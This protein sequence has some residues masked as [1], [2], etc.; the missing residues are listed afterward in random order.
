MSPNEGPFSPP[1]VVFYINVEDLDETNEAITENGGEILVEAM[2]VP[3]MGIFTIFQDPGGVINAA[4]ED[5]YEGEP[6]EGGWPMFTDQASDGSIVHF[7]LYTDDPEG[8]QAFHEA[9]FGWT[10]EAAEG[11][12]VMA[13]PPT[14]PYGGVMNAT[15]EMPVESLAYVLVEDAAEACEVIEGAQGEVLREPF[16][17]EG[18][19]TM[20][21]FEA[22]GEIVLALWE[23]AP[24]S[25][26][27]GEAEPHAA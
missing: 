5:R 1:T 18:W 26:D 24:E 25:M 15:D 8:T 20:A 14:P 13:Y 2:E 21:V 3:E 6:P 16:D 4:W 12:Y 11:D 19:G 9:V 7:E 27:A 10:F 17:I 23:S 22:P